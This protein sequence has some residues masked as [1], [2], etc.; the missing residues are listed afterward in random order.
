MA[1]QQLLWSILPIMLPKC[2]KPTRVM[3]IGRL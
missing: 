3:H 1:P 2:S